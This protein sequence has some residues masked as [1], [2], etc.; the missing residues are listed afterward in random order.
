[1]CFVVV[2]FESSYYLI[3]FVLLF[4]GLTH[5]FAVSPFVLSRNEFRVKKCFLGISSVMLMKNAK[6]ILV[7]S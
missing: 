5:L 7:K 6:L 1:M 4:S 3:Q 2:G